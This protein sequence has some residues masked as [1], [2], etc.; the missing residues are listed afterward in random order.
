MGVKEKIYFFGSNYFS[1]Y[2][3]FHK[4]QTSGTFQSQ[5]LFNDIVVYVQRENSERKYVVQQQGR[6][7]DKRQYSLLG[8]TF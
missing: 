8:L 1:F 3:C 2:F 6:H 5:K 7:R 4:R